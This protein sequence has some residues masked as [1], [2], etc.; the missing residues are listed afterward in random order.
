MDDNSGNKYRNQR[1]H[2]VV[3][4][5]N[6][7]TGEKSEK[8]R[9]DHSKSIIKVFRVFVILLVLT[10]VASG[11]VFI[12]QNFEFDF[13]LPGKSSNKSS[14]TETKV[15]KP[16]KPKKI[17]E[18]EVDFN[19]YSY[20]H[21]RFISKNLFYKNEFIDGKLIDSN[22][23][24]N[25]LSEKYFLTL[26]LEKLESADKKFET[27]DYCSY[28]SD[29]ETCPYA[30]VKAAYVE[31][32]LKRMFGN[33]S[34]KHQSTFMYV[35][36]NGYYY[37]YGKNY[38]TTFE[39][40]EGEA[41]SSPFK[42]TK[43]GSNLYIYAAVGVV[44]F[45]DMNNIRLYNSLDKIKTVSADITIGRFGIASSVDWLFDNESLIIFMKEHSDEFSQYRYTFKK[46]DKYYQFVDIERVK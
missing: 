19:T 4:I 34:Y 33:I 14:K 20:L 28:L 41:V 1:G 18:K 21:D 23:K 26:V 22:I 45:S 6:T 39:K 24:F 5:N 16:I 7:I 25:S 42:I 15:E 32:M 9:K 27:G 44:D 8:E 38:I 17:K 13:S 40:T 36:K 10:G 37:K 3:D 31:K 43:N 30:R 35:Y 11:L 29:K 2:R 12:L 46:V